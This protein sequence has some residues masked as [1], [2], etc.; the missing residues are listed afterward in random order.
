M[1]NLLLL[2]ILRFFRVMSH[3]KLDNLTSGVIYEV[4]PVRNSKTSKGSHFKFSLKVDH[5]IVKGTCFKVTEFANFVKAAEENTIVDFGQVTNVEHLEVAS[6]ATLLYGSAI[7]H[8]DKLHEEKSE[9]SCNA[10][11]LVS[12]RTNSFCDLL[13]FL[14]LYTGKVTVGC[15][16]QI[17]AKF[18][19]N[20]QSELVNGKEIALY[21]FEDDLEVEMIVKKWGTAEHLI[22]DRPYLIQGKVQA[23]KQTVFITVRTFFNSF[24]DLKFNAHFVKSF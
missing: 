5:Q 23:F 9:V 22:K 1:L 19:H 24:L 12:C 2:L 20:E 16:S 15:L 10:E 8:S 13:S 17:R 11:K 14:E 4:F 7:P 3:H 18:L 21:R 6:S